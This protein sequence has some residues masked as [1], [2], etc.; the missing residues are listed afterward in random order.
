VGVIVYGLLPQ[1][2]PSVVAYTLYRWECAIRASAILGFVG[3]GGL[4]QQLELSLRM[5][6]FNEVLTLLGI[7]FV[8]VA[9]VDFISGRVR[10]RVA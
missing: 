4:G 9:A 1:A 3:A 10:A 8:L 7:L 6:R 2:L 5:F